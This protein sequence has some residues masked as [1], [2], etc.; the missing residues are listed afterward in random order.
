MDNYKRWLF[1][2]KW[3]CWQALIGVLL[4]IIPIFISEKYSKLHVLWASIM[5][6]GV[7]SVFVSMFLIAIYGGKCDQKNWNEKYVRCPH[8]GNGWMKRK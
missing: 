8:C 3:G 4:F 7:L 5:F 2:A 1:W 6:I